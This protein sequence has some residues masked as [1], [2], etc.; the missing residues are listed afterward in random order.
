MQLLISGD[1]HFAQAL[2]LDQYLS[3]DEDGSDGVDV[4]NCVGPQRDAFNLNYADPALADTRVRQAISMALDRDALIA[5]AYQGLASP[6]IAG[7][8]QGF[9]D[10]LAKMPNY[11]Y[12]PDRAKELLAEAGHA[13]GRNRWRRPECFELEHSH[14]SC[15]SWRSRGGPSGRPGPHRGPPRH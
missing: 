7:L 15:G 9:K 13:H 11:Q 6:S 4:Y 3:L 2:T 14:R 5:G 1:V 10:G 8:H 12:D